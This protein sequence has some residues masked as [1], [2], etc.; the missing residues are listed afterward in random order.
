MRNFV[1]FSI[2]ETTI[3]V[4]TIF[5]CVVIFFEM[6]VEDYIKGIPIYINIFYWINYVLLLFFIV[7]IILKLFSLG[8]EFLREFINT[9][10]S[11]IVIISY[12]FLV[13][14]T[15]IPILGLLRTLRLL[16]VIASMKKIHDEKRARQESIKQ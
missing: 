7:E 16:K 15:R 8:F 3:L 4:M 14:N 6:A 11:I 9:F 2:V 10:D 1:E 13:M 5:L 12:I